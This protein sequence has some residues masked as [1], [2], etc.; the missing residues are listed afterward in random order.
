M[1]KSLL[2]ILAT[3][4]LLTTTAS[5]AGGH[6]KNEQFGKGH[7]G[8][9]MIYKKL[10]LSD[11]QKDQLKTIFQATREKADREAVFEAR[12]TFMQKR[13]AL[14]QSK[15]FDRAA[16]EALAK[17][18]SQEMEK[19]FVDMAEVEHK[20]W[21]VLTPEQQQEAKKMMEKRQD[22]LQKRLEKGKKDRKRQND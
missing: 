14:V 6:G 22:R 17:A 20:A 7:R 16:V 3:A 5:F 18:R 13:Q 1:K 19:R 9:L 11:T 8:P 12:K 2:A 15:T 10:D 21:Q 4:A